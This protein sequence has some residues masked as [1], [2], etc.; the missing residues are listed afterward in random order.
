[1]SVWSKKNNWDAEVAMYLTSLTGDD[2]TA[3]EGFIHDS[4]ISPV[5]HLTQ[6]QSRFEDARHKQAQMRWHR[7]DKHADKR[8]KRAVPPHRMKLHA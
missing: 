6:N 1:L 3:Q 5:F 7:F 8:K 2:K 4:G